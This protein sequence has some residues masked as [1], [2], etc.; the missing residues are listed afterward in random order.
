MSLYLGSSLS[1]KNYVGNNPVQKMYLGN[2]QIFSSSKY[3]I[4]SNGNQIP[5]QLDSQS[6]N[7]RTDFYRVQFA[8]CAI[9]STEHE[10]DFTNWASTSTG[11]LATTPDM[12]ISA[13]LYYK[14]LILDV[15]FSGNQTA[16]HAAGTVL[17]GTISGLNPTI[18]E[19]YGYLE[20]RRIGPSGTSNYPRSRVS[21]SGFGEG[22]R[23]ETTT[24]SFA[25]GNMPYGAKAT[26]NV[27]GG[28]IVSGTV[29]AGGARYTTSATLYAFEWGPDNKPYVKNIGTASRTGDAITGLSITSG[30]PPAGLAAWV[31]PTLFIGYGGAN[32]SSA[33]A[34]AGY[35][36][37]ALRGKCPSNVV[38]V[39]FIGDSII[40][41]NGEALPPDPD[42]NRGIYEIGI[43]NRCGVLNAGIGSAK[44]NV[45][46]NW[47]TNYPRL[48]AFVTG[49]CEKALL[50]VGTNDLRDSP[51]TYTTVR[52]NLQTIVS[53]L[54]G[55]GC[56]V[57][58]AT[59]LPRTTGNFQ[60]PINA[61]FD[62]GGGAFLINADI[63]SGVIPNDLGFVN[64]AALLRNPSDERWWRNDFSVTTDWTHP[65]DA[66]LR[67]AATDST[68]QA[69]F[70]NLVS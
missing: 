23:L 70:D 69:S 36:H 48:K 12:T 9:G 15:L 49:K 44:A 45:I 53:N 38:S 7:V 31:N 37:S 67:L 41:G 29:T 55:I 56:S 60:T 4:I 8:D 26:A 30:T 10:I 47:D 1:S 46:A 18:D 57:K 39:L 5:F 11:E 51:T 21:Y 2:T 68:F 25:I 34:I 28:N 65:R 3:A 58:T 40:R 66:A 14:N 13:K 17:T 63:A 27:S 42:N 54:R 16:T 59:I 62:T 6:T 33:N 19:M 52:S 64:G 35:G 50:A 32:L 61:A 43:S 24:S 22:V 20:I